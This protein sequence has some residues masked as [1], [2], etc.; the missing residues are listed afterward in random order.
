MAE[1]APLKQLGTCGEIIVVQGWLVLLLKLLAA[2][3]GEQTLQL[4]ERLVDVRND[5]ILRLLVLS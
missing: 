1:P 2:A 3:S 4:V 5:L